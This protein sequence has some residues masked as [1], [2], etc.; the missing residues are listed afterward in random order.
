VAKVQ[1]QE[2]AKMYSLEESHWWFAGKREIVFEFVKKIAKKGDRILDVGCGTGIVMEKADRYGSVYGLDYSKEAL[3][4]CRK[5]GLSNLTL[6]SVMSLP[7]EDDEFDLVLCLDVLYHKGISD[8]RQALRELFRVI[9][10]GGHL[11]ITDS[12]TK[13]LFSPHDL[14]TEA[15]ERYSAA[16]MRGKVK[17]AG[18]SVRRISYFNFFLFPVIF[19]VRKFRALIH[20]RGSDVQEAPALMNSLLFRILWLESRLLQKLN[21][22][23]GVSLFCLA[24]KPLS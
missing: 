1:K 16:E 18:F 24:R 15:R 20:A 3:A 6:G 5:R 14:A 13:A 23:W 4:F 19:A 8:D 22:P 10:P 2:Y 9:K 17:S 12:A 21:F 11:L 7:Y